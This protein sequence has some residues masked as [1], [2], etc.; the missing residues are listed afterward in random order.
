MMTMV[1]FAQGNYRFAWIMLGCTIACF[2]NVLFYSK[3]RDMETSLNQNKEE[4]ENLQK[5]IENVKKNNQ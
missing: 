4:I 1:F 5:Q 2:I 3:L